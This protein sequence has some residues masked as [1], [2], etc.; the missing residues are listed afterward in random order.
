MTELGEGPENT[1]HRSAVQDLVVMIP[2]AIKVQTE[3]DH[4]VALL[5]A[6]LLPVDLLVT[7]PTEA[8][9]IHALREKMRS[10]WGK[11]EQPNTSINGERSESAAQQ[12]W[13]EARR[14]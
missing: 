6:W 7:A 10:Y 12:S 11:T 14:G 13:A 4:V 1:M 2:M 5:P 9:A 3:G 8:E